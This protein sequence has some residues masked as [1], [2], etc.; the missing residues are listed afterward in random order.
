MTGLR[1]IVPQ[2]V[3]PNAILR[4]HPVDGPQNA[5]WVQVS[6]VRCTPEDDQWELGCEFMRTPSWSVLLQF[7]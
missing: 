5:P 7:N 1:L 6:V 2:A 4:V 3:A